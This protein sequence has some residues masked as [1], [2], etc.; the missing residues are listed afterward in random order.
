MATPRTVMQFE[1]RGTFPIRERR[2]GSVRYPKPGVSRE[3]FISLVTCFPITCTL[4]VAI[5]YGVLRLAR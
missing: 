5:I 4:W 1:S 3:F 2:S